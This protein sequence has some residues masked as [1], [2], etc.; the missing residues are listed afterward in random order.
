[1]PTTC[2][3]WAIHFARGEFRVSLENNSELQTY[4][5]KKVQGPCRDSTSLPFLS[6]DFFGVNKDS[7]TGCALHKGTGRDS[8]GPEVHPSH[9]PQ[10]ANPDM[11]C[12]PPG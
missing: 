2:Q 11:W 7:G 1:M 8:V 4:L 12:H 5:L 9:T 3:S 6:G 10:V